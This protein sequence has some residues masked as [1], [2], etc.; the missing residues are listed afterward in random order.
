[1]NKTENTNISCDAETGT[2]L[3]SSIS[4]HQEL[5][6][7]NIT[8]ASKAKLVYYY[9]ALC[10][11]CYGFSPVMQKVKQAYGALLHIEVVSGGLFLNGRVGLVND[12]APHIKAGA[13]KSVEARTG[14]KFGAV[15]LKDVF[16]EGKMVLDSLP[17]AIA[18][19]IIKEK[20]P[21]KELEFAELL[22]DAVYFDGM[23]PVNLEEYTVYVEKMGLDKAVFFTE[24]NNPKYRALAE[25]E[26]EKFTA[27]PFTGMPTLVLETEEKHE[28]LASGFSDFE[29]I[30]SQLDLFLK[31]N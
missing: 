6:E 14:V 13:Y 5:V 9:D 3:P 4:N 12:V 7:P 26:F 23:N 10:G 22:L 20:F 1:M 18:L 31:N 30:K 28:V 15:F 11:W 2:C 21:E 8:K 16:G 19:C 27:S 17:P 24:M 29:N 25:K